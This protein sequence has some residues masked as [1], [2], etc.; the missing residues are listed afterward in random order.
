MS[1]RIA[2]FLPNLGAGGAERVVVQLAN[3]FANRGIEVDLVVG[4]AT[5]PLRAHI[6]P[7]VKLVDLGA[8]RTWRSLFGLIRYVRENRPK[9]MLSTLPHANIV[10]GIALWVARVP[11]RWV[12]RE[13]NLMSVQRARARGIRSILSVRASVF[14]YRYAAAVVALAE[15]MAADLQQEYGVPATKIAIIYNPV[16][17]LDLRARAAV[18]VAHPWLAANR[19]MPV[20]V[21]VGRLEPQK[22]Y[23]T[24]LRAFAKVSA[25]RPVRLIILGEGSQ[26]DDL[27]AL[28]RELSIADRVD[29][30]GYVQNPSPFVVSCDAFVMSSVYEGMPNA[31]IEALALG[32][33]IVSTDCRSGPKEVLDYGRHGRLVPVSDVDA[34]SREIHAALNHPVDRDNATR[35][36]WVEERFSLA[37]IVTKY[38]QV[39]D[40]Q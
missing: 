39:L 6:A 19:P 20:I 31:L 12:L 7:R 11:V 3:E 24:L 9:A 28:A 26:R 23:P 5:G 17:I 18:G 14:A 37:A 35:N 29:L 30:H 2:L 27:L 25:V 36:R 21:S 34:L 13:A 1:G 10:A 40:P 15:E 32:A 22:D 38:R 4:T 16:D 33:T 8:R